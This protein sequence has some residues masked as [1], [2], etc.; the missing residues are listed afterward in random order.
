MF[1]RDLIDLLLDHPQSIQQLA[2]ELRLPCHAVKD[3]LE[4]LFKSLKHTEYDAV[5][6]PARCRK[7]GFEFARDKLAKPSRCPKCRSTW[8]TEPRISIERKDS[9]RP[10][11]DSCG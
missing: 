1:R 10:S 4:H 6:A 5:V 7:C 3:D 8:L 2:R 9:D 11:R